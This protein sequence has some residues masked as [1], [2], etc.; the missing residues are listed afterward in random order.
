MAHSDGSRTI[1]KETKVVITASTMR[2]L[3]KVL[4]QL[5]V[6]SARYGRRE[7]QI[8]VH[9]V[10]KKQWSMVV[11]AKPLNAEFITEENNHYCLTVGK[12]TSITHA[13][14]SCPYFHKGFLTRKNS[15]CHFFLYPARYHYKNWITNLCSIASHTTSVN[16]ETCQTNNYYWQS[17]GAWGSPEC[18]SQY[19][20]CKYPVH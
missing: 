10:V 4:V 3:G 7:T 16:H 17:R 20:S 18:R 11:R 13:F 12:A 19:T 9:V 6:R 5:C 2:Y 8:T 15:T 14:V 1:E